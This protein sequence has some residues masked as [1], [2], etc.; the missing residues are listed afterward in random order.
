ME[1]FDRAKAVRLRGRHGKYLMAG[2]DEEHVIQSRQGSHHAA[3]WGVEFVDGDRT[4]RLRSCYGRFLAATSEHFLLGATGKKVIQAP[5]AGSR[6]DSSLEW[7]PVRDGFQVKLKS[8]S[9]HF[10][11]ANGGVPPWRNSVTHD[12]PHRTATQDWVLWDV[13]IVQIHPT[14]AR[15]R[16]FAAKAPSAM[17]PPSAA[18]AVPPSST[19]RT[20]PPSGPSDPD[21]KSPDFSSSRSTSRSSSPDPESSPHKPTFSPTLSNRQLA[22]RTCRLHVS[23]LQAPAPGRTIHYTVADDNG[24]VDASMEWS[25]LTFIGTSVPELTSKLK[26]MTRLDDIIVC[27]RNPLNHRLSPLYLQLPPNNRTMQLV[28]VDA[29]SSCEFSLTLRIMLFL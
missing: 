24:N 12:V 29:E 2:E 23:L 13:D 5:A 20:S 17:P 22:L 14:P 3:C 15:L 1:L 8:Y 21:K 19:L 27:T 10:L 9:G 11:R 4:L 6:H 18:P 16:S 25:S 7:E 26:K 28:V